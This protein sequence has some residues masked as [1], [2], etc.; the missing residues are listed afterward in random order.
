M[1]PPTLAEAVRLARAVDRGIARMRNVEVVIAPPYP[2]LAPLGRLLKRSKL[3]AQ[4]VAG[5]ERGAYT[6]EVSGR[7]LRDLGVAY[8]I[9]GHSERRR[10][11]GED[12]AT[13][14][15]KVR[16]ALDARLVPIMAIGEDVGES[17]EVVP[18]RLALELNQA[19]G[20]I[21]KRKLLRAC[22]AYEPVGAISTTPGAKPD[23]P[24]HATRRAI[25]IRKL[26]TKLLGARVTDG[27]RIIY[28]GSVNSKN[29]RAFIADDIR[30]MEGLLVGGAS[31]DAGEFVGIVESVARKVRRHWDSG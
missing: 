8:V 30:G 21:P 9:I 24:D 15:R 14:N 28:G 27:I 13:I 4:D 23:S 11:F 5:A 17:Q 20:G 25:Y 16:S 7:M 2:Y 3:G 1:N 26:V 22:I 6:G 31:L 12:G 29:A 18:K 10:M 19:F